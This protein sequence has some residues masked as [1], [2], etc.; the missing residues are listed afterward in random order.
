MI[1]QPH[2]DEKILILGD[3]RSHSVDKIQGSF[4]AGIGIR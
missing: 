3:G 4:A 2:A 1:S